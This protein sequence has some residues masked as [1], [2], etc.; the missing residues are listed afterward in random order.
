MIARIL[1][2]IGLFVAT[3]AVTPT[4]AASKVQRAYDAC[5]DS[6]NSDYQRR[7]NYKA[8][9]AGVG[10]FKTQ[11]YWSWGYASDGDA[12]R[13]AFANCEKKFKQCYLYASTTGHSSWSQRISDLGG[14]DGSRERDKRAAAAIVNFASGLAA[15]LANS[16]GGGGSGGGSGGGGHGDGCASDSTCDH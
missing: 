5:V 11:C 4:F 12:I 16:G 9:V 7:P 10:L 6:Y 15:A 1:F 8:I 14:S 3:F 13:H 2:A